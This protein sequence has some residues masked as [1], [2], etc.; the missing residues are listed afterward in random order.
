MI[1][2]ELC[3]V[4]YRVVAGVYYVQGIGG[5]TEIIDLQLVMTCPMMGFSGWYTADMTAQVMP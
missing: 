1:Y 4:I 2:L 5:L 3:W